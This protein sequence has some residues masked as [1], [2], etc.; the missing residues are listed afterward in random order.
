MPNQIVSL[1]PPE[2]LARLEQRVRRLRVILWVLAAVGLT[3]CVLLT[4]FSNTANSSAM[5]L[6]TMAV[7]ILVGWVVIYLAIFGVGDGKK[8][9]SHAAHLADDEPQTV[10]GTVRVDPRRFRIRKSITVQKVFVRT[11]TG[12]RSFLVNASRAGELSRAGERLTLFVR[13]GYVAAYEVCP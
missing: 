5:M 2:R 11:E 4:C 8:E 10:T 6:R 7:S 12:E 9:L 13:H 3:A 1:Y